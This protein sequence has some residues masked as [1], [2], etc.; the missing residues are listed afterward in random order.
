[1]LRVLEVG[2]VVAWKGGG[3]WEVEAGGLVGAPWIVWSCLEF[4]GGAW[5]SLGGFA[6][7]S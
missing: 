6:G 2:G 1:M 5:E 4:H 7:A 3:P